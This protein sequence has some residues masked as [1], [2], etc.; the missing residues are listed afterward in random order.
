MGHVEEEIDK[1][2]RH[3]MLNGIENVNLVNMPCLVRLCPVRLPSG[4]RSN[5]AV[6]NA[7]TPFSCSHIFSVHSYPFSGNIYGTL[8]FLSLAVSIPP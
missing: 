5:D 7:P 3:V 4:Y 8:S 6:N 2:A 1:S